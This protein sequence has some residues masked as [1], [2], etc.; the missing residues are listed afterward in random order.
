MYWSVKLIF[1]PF[2]LFEIAL[3][4]FFALSL[5]TGIIGLFASIGKLAN[6]L[7]YFGIGSVICIMLNLMSFAYCCKFY[8]KY[9]E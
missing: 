3:V 8:K 7:L 1:K 4:I 2:A 5:C 9:I 6:Q